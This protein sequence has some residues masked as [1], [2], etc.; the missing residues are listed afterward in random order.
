MTIRGYSSYVGLH[1]STSLILLAVSSEQFHIWATSTDMS[2]RFL[3]NMQEEGFL[4]NNE[5][6]STALVVVGRAI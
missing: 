6:S 3:S 5:S 4:N 2:L 1:K